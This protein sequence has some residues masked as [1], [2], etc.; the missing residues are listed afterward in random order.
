MEA[1]PQGGGLALVA[2]LVDGFQLRPLGG[3]G[4]EF[5]GGGILAGIVDGDDFVVQSE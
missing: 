3:L 4:V 1:D 5:G 2:W